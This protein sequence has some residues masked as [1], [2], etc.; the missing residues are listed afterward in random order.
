MICYFDLTWL[1]YFTTLKYFTPL[2]YFILLRFYNFTVVI[3]Q[4]TEISHDNKIS[5]WWELSYHV[6]TS[7]YI[8]LSTD[9]L[10]HFM[11]FYVII[12]HQKSIQVILSYSCLS[13]RC[14][15]CLLGM[16]FLCIVISERFSCHWKN[17]RSVAIKNVIRSIYGFRFWHSIRTIF[18]RRF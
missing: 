15:P 13:V 1:K 16:H 10:S 7:T 2:K 11:S 4:Y 8:V 17:Q 9:C 3:F 14:G 12:S 18:L 5:L 6:D